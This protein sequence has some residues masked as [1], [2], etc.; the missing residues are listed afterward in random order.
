[1]RTRCLSDDERLGLC[2]ITRI[3]ERIDRC[4]VLRCSQSRS[5]VVAPP[6]VSNELSLPRCAELSWDRP[7]SGIRDS[8]LRAGGF[9]HV[10][11]VGVLEET[12]Q[13]L[14][15]V[16]DVGAGTSLARAQESNGLSLQGGSEP[17][18]C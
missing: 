7:A 3:R 9:A 5:K 8:N 6:D 12:G 11:G 10:F 18:A 16:F 1:M 2:F 17:P 13:K 14:C 15:E 4:P